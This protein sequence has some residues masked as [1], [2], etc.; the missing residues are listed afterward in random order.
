[1]REHATEQDLRR[2][3]LIAGG[4]G[5]IGGAVAGML[6]AR[7]DIV[8]VGYRSE[9]EAAVARA[10]QLQAEHGIPALAVPLDVRDRA[11]IDAAV[12]VLLE[13]H[14]RVDILV[15]AAGITGDR[16]LSKLTAADFDDVLQVNLKGAFLLMQ[17]VLPAMRRGQYGRIVN[18][19]S[20]AGIQG[21]IGQTAYAASKAALIGLTKTAALEE[22]AHGITINAVAPSVTE[23]KLTAQL[24]AEATARLLQKIP[25]GRMQTPEE[26]A[27]LIAW[28]TA[29]GAGTIS[30][31]VFTGDN[32]QYGW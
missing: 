25:L 6:A 19:T 1:M 7:G 21:R 11:S 20:Y 29:E 23:S 32:R 30:G 3:A 4:S 13:Q 22:I 14:G 16:M 17:A 15:N 31:Q 18:I 24:A 26:A 10:G 27:G 12:Q 28:L 9:R 2:V 5:A 8:A